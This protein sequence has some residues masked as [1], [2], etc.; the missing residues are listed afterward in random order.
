MKNGR[1]IQLCK[2]CR[3]LRSRVWYAENKNLINKRIRAKRRKDRVSTVLMDSRKSDR[4]RGFIVNDE[5]VDYE[6]ARI[7]LG[8]PCSYCGDRSIQMTLDRIDNSIGHT[9]SN[10]VPACIR[11]NLLRRS[12]P[13]DAWVVVAKGVREARELGLFESWTGQIHKGDR[14]RLPVRDDLVV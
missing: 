7:L 6:T 1:Y 13:Y 12:M 5:F 8:N 9:K 3:N 11:C 4:K 10:V 14:Q 2:P